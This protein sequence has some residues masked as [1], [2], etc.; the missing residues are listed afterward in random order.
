[1]EMLRIAVLMTSAVAIFNWFSRENCALAMGF[2]TFHVPITYFLCWS[3]DGKDD[4][5]KYIGVAAIVP[6][7][8]VLYKFFSMDPVDEG[9]IINEQE[10]IIKS[11]LPNF[12]SQSQES[13]E[14]AIN[15]YLSQKL[16]FRAKLNG[17][18]E[19]EANG[20][21]SSLSSEELK[22][23][24]SIDFSKRSKERKLSDPESVFF[25]IEPERTRTLTLFKASDEKRRT[26]RYKKIYKK[27]IEELLYREQ[28][29]GVSF[30]EVL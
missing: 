2:L 12:D 8:F 29:K 22:E 11:F 19:T 14:D 13:K 18:D 30:M 20:K 21:E 23:L 1:M 27:V 15:F 4:I 26:S 3:A 24:L 28:R 6:L 10:I 5:L 16:R 9:K 25:G 17:S 7:V